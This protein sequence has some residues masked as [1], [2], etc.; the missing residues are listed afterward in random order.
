MHPLRQDFD[1]TLTLRLATAADLPRVRRLAALDCAR[2]PKAPV[3]I[4]ELDEEL[5]VAVSL[6]DFKAVADPFRHTDGIRA[7]AL[8]RA[9]QPRPPA[10]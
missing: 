6:V 8:A 10:A 1:S 5:C 7:L 3:L 2:P 4:A 9:N